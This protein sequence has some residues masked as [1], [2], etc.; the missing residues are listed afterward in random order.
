[1]PRFGI[2]TRIALPLSKPAL[3]IITVF[4]FMNHWNS[5]LGPLI[6][7]STY[8]NYTLALGLRFF[9]DRYVVEWTQLMAA[10]LIVLLPCL[11]VFFIAQKYYIQG[12]II[13]GVKG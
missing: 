8:D 11:V 7:L 1:M 13:T 4:S 3:G 12:I 10:S 6:Y 2:F 5:F 9:R